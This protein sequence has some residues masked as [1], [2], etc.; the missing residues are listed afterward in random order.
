MKNAI[1]VALV[2]AQLIGCSGDGETSSDT[3]VARKAKR[4]SATSA[5]ASAR[6]AATRASGAPA[7]VSVSVAT[8]VVVPPPAVEPWHVALLQ[9]EPAA[10][11]K[12]DRG[13][14]SP[15][16]GYRLKYPAS[17]KASTGSDFFASNAE[18][19]AFFF[20]A[21]AGGAPPERAAATFAKGALLKAS[22]YQIVTDPLVRPLGSARFPVKG[23]EAPGCK[24][25]GEEGSFAW[26]ELCTNNDGANRAIVFL[27]WKKSVREQAKKELAAIAKS[28]SMSTVAGKP[29]Y[30]LP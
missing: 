27:A 24:L 30:S 15:V 11:V 26:F 2:V 18:K 3:S 17:W 7:S 8:P 5:S 16:A 25:D 10:D 14:V 20:L 9:G 21:D 28:T 6:S 1:R 13:W 12:L 19:T 4:R 23:G 22:D 29:C